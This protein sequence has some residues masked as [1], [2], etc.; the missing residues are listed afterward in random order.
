M[1]SLDEMKTNVDKL[2]EIQQQLDAARDELEGLNVEEELLEWQPSQFPQLQQM[3]VN[4]Q[5]YD[6][7]W[8]TAL[9]FHTKYEEWLNGEFHT[10][11]W[12]SYNW[13]YQGIMFSIKGCISHL[14]P[15]K[16]FGN[17]SELKKK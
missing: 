10:Q 9:N 13:Q 17:K 3:F 1:L 15:M 4:K 12:G 2:S 11:T 5:P 16:R 7:L 14:Q 8:N 6:S